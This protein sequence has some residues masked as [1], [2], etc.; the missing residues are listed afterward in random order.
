MVWNSNNS[1]GSGQEDGSRYDDG[2]QGV[3]PG[4]VEAGSF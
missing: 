2:M 3:C 1:T 4:V